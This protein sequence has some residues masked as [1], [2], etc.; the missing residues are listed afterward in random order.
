MVYWKPDSSPLPTNTCRCRLSFLLDLVLSDYAGFPESSSW[1]STALTLRKTAVWVAN[2]LSL[3]CSSLKWIKSLFS[4]SSVAPK[5]VKC[6]TTRSHKLQIK[7]S[8]KSVKGRTQIKFVTIFNWLTRKSSILGVLCYR[9]SCIVLIL[10]FL[11]FFKVINFRGCI[12][13]A[14]TV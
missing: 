4:W 6:K 5:V 13:V 9:V 2:Y 3:L 1:L 8:K 14:A 7:Q 10:Y 11:W 12:N